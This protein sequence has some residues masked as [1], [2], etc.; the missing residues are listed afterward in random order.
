MCKKDVWP[1]AKAI[2]VT[3]TRG[4]F[5][6]SRGQWLTSQD[7]GKI[8]LAASTWR[9]QDRGDYEALVAGLW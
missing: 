9:L 1:T 7:D 5:Q 2:L 3:R 4:R 8:R 6:A